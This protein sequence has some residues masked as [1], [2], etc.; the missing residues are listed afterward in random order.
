MYIGLQ[1]MYIYL[2]LRK[3]YS[4]LTI[5][6]TRI[7]SELKELADDSLS[8]IKFSSVLL[9]LSIY[10]SIGVDVLELLHT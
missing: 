1:G 5:V 7:R 3:I 4:F 10:L 6:Q 8:L 2:L 9:R